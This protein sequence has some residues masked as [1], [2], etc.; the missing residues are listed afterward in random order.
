MQ[1]PA[2]DLA[3][4]LPGGRT[5]AAFMGLWDQLTARLLPRNATGA[6]ADT[7]LAAIQLLMAATAAQLQ[8]TQ[9]LQHSRRQVQQAQQQHWQL[10]HQ[11]PAEDFQDSQVP[12]GPSSDVSTAALQSP[13]A[14]S[15]PE[16]PAQ[17]Q[18][19][20][21]ITGQLLSVAL[22]LAD[23]SAAGIPLDAEA[24]AAGVLAEAVLSEQLSMDS[25]QVWVVLH[26]VHCLAS[27]PPGCL[28]VMPRFHALNE[29]IISGF[30]QGEAGHAD[31]EVAFRGH[32]GAR[33]V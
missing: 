23:L 2:A 25:V 14:A 17:R 7:L 5:L 19:M 4:Q 31:G 21:I 33:A 1:Q 8:P 6:S 30:F 20:P 29:T 22:Q 28:P 15:R 12:P 3:L 32:R 11:S 27:G 13:A 24:I 10:P 18:D 9:P 26:S 16:A